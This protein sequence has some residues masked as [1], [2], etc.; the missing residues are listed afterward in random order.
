M[1]F[2]C[3]EKASARRQ[4]CKAKNGT[5]RVR[6]P[7]LA[8][9]AC[10]SRFTVATYERSPWLD[11]GASREVDYDPPR[12]SVGLAANPVTNPY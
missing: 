1:R 3:E 5:A 12:K 11:A 6:L 10:P 7:G 2:I 9:C 4:P 8:P